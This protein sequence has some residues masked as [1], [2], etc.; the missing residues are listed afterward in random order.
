M[1]GISLQIERQN[2]GSAAVGSNVV[3][4]TT[5]TTSGNV[6]YDDATGIITIEDPGKYL[7]NW[8]VATQTTQSSNGVVF[9]ISSSQGDLLEGT[10][11]IRTGEVYG[12][13]LIIVDEIDK[14]R[15]INDKIILKSKNQLLNE[16][17][18]LS[19]QNEDLKH[20]NYQLKYKNEELEKQKNYLLYYIK[21]FLDKMPK[22]IKDIIDK[23]FDR[24]LSVDLYKSQYDPEMLE[25]QHKRIEANNRRFNLFNKREIEKATKHLNNEMDESAEEFYKTKKDD[26]LER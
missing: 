2:S 9:A 19:K 4:D 25:E 11:P 20:E 3:F 15:K 18:K 22:V 12:T 13:G 10:S 8:W 14:K 26:G 5:V 1:D 6:S 24:N 23:V 17:Q 16:N 21:K 7:I